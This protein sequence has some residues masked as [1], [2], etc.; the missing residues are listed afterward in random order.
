MNDGWEEDGHEED[1]EEAVWIPQRQMQTAVQ[2]PSWVGEISSPPPPP[3]RRAV[4]RRAGSRATLSPTPRVASGRASRVLSMTS[5]SSQLVRQLSG[6][7]QSRAAAPTSKRWTDDILPSVMPSP[8]RDPPLEPGSTQPSS[9]TP[10]SRQLAFEFD[11]SS[12][13]QTPVKLGGGRRRT[14][15]DERLAED[16]V[17]PPGNRQQNPERIT[18]QISRSVAHERESIESLTRNNEGEPVPSSPSPKL[19]RWLSH[20]DLAVSSPTSQQR[21][22]DVGSGL[23]RRRSLGQLSLRFRS[24][25]RRLSLPQPTCFTDMGSRP[26]RSNAF[27]V[28]HLRRHDF[29]SRFDLHCC[30]SLVKVIGSSDVLFADVLICDDVWCTNA[31][32]TGSVIATS[33]REIELSIPSWPRPILLVTDFRVVP[34][35]DD[36]AIPLLQLQEADISR[37]APCPNTSQV[38]TPRP[39]TAPATSTD[40]N[41]ASLCGIIQRVIVRGCGN[42]ASP[43]LRC[44]CLSLLVQDQ[45]SSSLFEVEFGAE[46]EA[47]VRRSQGDCLEFQRLQRRPPPE[48]K[49]RDCTSFALLFDDTCHDIPVFEFVNGVSSA[50]PQSSA[51]LPTCYRPPVIEALADILN[52][53]SR[54]SEVRRHS[55]AVWVVCIVAAKS[56]GIVER[57]F[58]SDGSLSDFETGS[59]AITLR[60]DLRE[61]SAA[62]LRERGSPVICQDLCVQRLD[63][64][65]IE[66]T[67][68]DLSSIVVSPD[69]DIPVMTRRPD[70][71]TVPSLRF[72][73]HVVL[74]LTGRIKAVT[75]VASHYRYT[76]CQRTCRFNDDVLGVPCCP[77]CCVEGCFLVPSHE[78]T[79]TVANGIEDF[80]VQADIG[81]LDR[82]GMSIGLELAQMNS[83]AVYFQDKPV[84]LTCILVD[85]EGQNVWK[86]IGHI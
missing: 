62:L 28:C 17:P 77:Y 10:L 45:E 21:R 30:V 59:C 8:V 4:R 64:H 15:D 79:I 50:I 70:R 37:N 71:S 48:L 55:C 33:G 36:L 22:P 13:A 66:M 5:Q 2:C 41:S 1:E 65:V 24:I 26:S 49:H 44:R 39:E 25:S 14:A 82:H 75:H 63:N 67:L 29:D 74:E 47:Q 54:S 32:Q 85:D 69:T 46:L 34:E 7:R 43:I 72:Q 35:S 11:D 9:H 3:P 56:P 53:T 68:D 12:S 19:P 18:A 6:A 51:S 83:V 58:V 81:L 78:L 84:A 61:Q 31:L 16:I 52:A 73:P 38:S 57:I 86:A 60:G 76:K 40:I 80:D 20:D 23:K 27:R 42:H